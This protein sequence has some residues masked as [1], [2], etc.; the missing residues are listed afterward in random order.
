MSNK[1]SS[2]FSNA[3]VA[4]KAIA[5]AVPLLKGSSKIEFGLTCRPLI[6]SAVIN[7]CS[8]LQIN[9]GLSKFLR[10]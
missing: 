7:L 2:L 4:D 6:C 1:A 5:G 9:I 10:F 8:S 3:L